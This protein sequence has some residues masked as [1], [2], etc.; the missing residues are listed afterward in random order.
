[1]AA[2]RTR[3]LVVSGAGGR[4]G[5][6]IVAEA[7]ARGWAI[8]GAIGGERSVRAA[9]G[10]GPRPFVLD[11][12]SALSRRLEGAG[13]YVGAATAAAERENLERAA[14]AGV[15]AV[16][17]TTGFVAA[18]APWLDSVAHRIPLVIDPNFSV[19]IAWLMRRIGDGSELPPGF[20]VA[21]VEAHR[22]GK[23]D[24]PSGTAARWAGRLARPPVA[25][26]DS[27][28]PPVEISSVRAGEL[29]GWHSVWIA[30]PHELIR[31]EHVA[32]DRAAFADG[33]LVAAERLADGAWPPG[34][35]TLADV[36]DRSTEVP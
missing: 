19:G 30:G 34:R 23:L 8:H 6:A 27:P 26:D 5:R 22:R 16:V 15:P 13:I 3:R 20:D 24:R 32:F 10:S 18:D 1:M 29:P 2:A 4:L 14:R 7:A 21:I 35:Y 33:V 17:A 36:L 9:E 11:P 12:P 28:P 31:V 25:A